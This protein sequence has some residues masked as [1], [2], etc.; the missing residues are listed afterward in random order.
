MAR[1]NDTI[2]RVIYGIHN[3]GNMTWGAAKALAAKNEGK[4]T[5]N[6]KR[7]PNVVQITG[8]NVVMLKS[9]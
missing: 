2:V 8:G 6:T 4:I 7:E 9:G 3:V 5:I 1:T